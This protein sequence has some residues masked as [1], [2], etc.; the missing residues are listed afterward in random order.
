MKST[1]PNPSALAA[2]GLAVSLADN[3]VATVAP[4]GAPAAKTAKDDKT[5]KEP[6]H[7][8]AFAPPPAGAAYDKYHGHGGRFALINGKRVP[9]DDEGQPLPLDEDGFPLPPAATDAA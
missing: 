2:V 6:K 7:E 9:V 5:A 3:T 4:A 1:Q 8:P